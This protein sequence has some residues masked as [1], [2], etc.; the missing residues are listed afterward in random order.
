MFF[1]KI[2]EI[3]TKISDSYNHHLPTTLP[4]PTRTYHPHP[5]PCHVVHAS[6]AQ[7]PPKNPRSAPRGRPRL[8][9][10]RP[11]VPWSDI[12][13]LGRGSTTRSLKDLRSSNHGVPN[14]P[15]ISSGI[16]LRMM[17]RMCFPASWSIPLESHGLEEDPFFPCWGCTC[18][19]ARCYTSGGY[20]L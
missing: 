20:P 1:T 2:S 5:P 3:Q 4:S 19:A 16:K 6:A 12:T 11:M 8:T 13:Q 7:N 10:R 9:H 15:L 17:H 14:E 18:S